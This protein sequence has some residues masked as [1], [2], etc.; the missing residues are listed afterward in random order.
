MVM[1]KDT[2]DGIKDGI[3]GA[4]DLGDLVQLWSF[5]AA[6][7]LA[8]TIIGLVLSKYLQQRA[9][10]KSFVSMSASENQ[11]LMWGSERQ[12]AAKTDDHRLYA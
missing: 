8:A 12:P 2:A 5:V 9:K 10:G 1:D 4:Q 6:G 11:N 7:I 3:Y